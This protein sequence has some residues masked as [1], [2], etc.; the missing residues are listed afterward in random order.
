MIEP[1]H[2]AL[3]AG[4]VQGYI[5]AWNH[6]VTSTLAHELWPDGVV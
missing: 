2:L 6:F 1:K 4:T 3:G 5:D